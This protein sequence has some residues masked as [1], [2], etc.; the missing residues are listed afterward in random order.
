MGLHWI[1]ADGTSQTW[2]DAPAAPIKTNPPTKESWRRC[3]WS[4]I[5]IGLF[6]AACAY[7]GVFS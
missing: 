7:V 5:A 3:D 1:K 4:V 6:A 2:H